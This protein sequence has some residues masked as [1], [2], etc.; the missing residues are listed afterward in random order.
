MEGINHIPIEFN[1]DGT[2]K[3]TAN[4]LTQYHSIKLED[5]QRAAFTQYGTSLAVADPIPE[6]RPFEAKNLS[7]GTSADDKK[8]FYKKVHANVIAKMV[9]RSLPFSIQQQRRLSS[10]APR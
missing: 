10:M 6:D 7:P 2:V 3:T 4:L 1:A 5:C 8:Q 9:E